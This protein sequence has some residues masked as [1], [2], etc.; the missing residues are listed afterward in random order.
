MSVRINPD[1]KKPDS[2]ITDASPIQAKSDNLSPDDSLHMLI[3]P[4][5]GKVA[6]DEQ[7]K[8]F[9]DELSGEDQ[10]KIINEITKD[11]AHEEEGKPAPQSK[12]ASDVPPVPGAISKQDQEESKGISLQRLKT[13]ANKGSRVA[14]KLSKPGQDTFGIDLTDIKNIEDLFILKTRAEGLD[15]DEVKAKEE[16]EA[17]RCM[18]EVDQYVKIS[19]V[20]EILAD[21]LET[22]QR[23]L[24][25][26]DN[27]IR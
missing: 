19:E 11:W 25:Q 13:F 18:F 17:K 10:D 14:P 1:K 23:K 21:G 9:D 4:T 20:K 15:K 27:T 5:D 16:V 2:S 8:L 22:L 3:N 6:M 24:M 7:E 12:Q 26:A